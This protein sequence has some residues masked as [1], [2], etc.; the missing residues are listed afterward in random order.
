M[1]WEPLQLHKFSDHELKLVHFGLTMEL[2]SFETDHPMTHDIDGN[3]LPSEEE[4]KA[5]LLAVEQELIRR[6]RMKFH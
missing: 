2:S 3:E 1:P 5:Q 6:H 4:L